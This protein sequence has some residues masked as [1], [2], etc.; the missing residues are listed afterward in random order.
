MI[1]TP[2]PSLSSNHPFPERESAE[3]TYSLSDDYKR[4]FDRVLRYARE[5]VLEPGMVVLLEPGVYIPEV[6]G[7]RQERMFLITDDGAELMT[8]NPLD[9]T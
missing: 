6:G 3:E 9:L 8:N 4:L 5:T 2:G 1:V 7:C